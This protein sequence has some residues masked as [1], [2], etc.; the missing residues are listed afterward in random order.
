[1]KTE[2]NIHKKMFLLQQEIGAISKDASNPFYKSKY[3]DINSLIKQ[4]QPLLKKHNVLLSQPTRGKKVFTILKCVESETSD[5]SWLKLP[6]INDPQK[7]GSCIT[8]Y[9]RYTLASLLGLQAEDDDGNT[10]SNKAVE[11]QKWLNQNTP[12]YSKAI[13]FIKG[14][15]SVEAIKSKYKVSKKVQDELAKL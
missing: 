13:E 4:L 11:E 3:F 8:Y 5:M 2:T 1:M 12:E 6:E 10:A 15:G 7:L 9:R 14:G